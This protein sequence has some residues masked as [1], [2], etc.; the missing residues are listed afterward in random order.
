LWSLLFWSGGGLWAALVFPPVL[1]KQKLPPRPEP[2]ARVD[3][4]AYTITITVLCTACTLGVLIWQPGSNG[5]WLVVTVLAVTQAGGDASMKRTLARIAGTVV[6]V[7]IAGLVASVS[8]S[9]AVL[10]GVGLILLVIMVVI[11]LG[12]HSY[13]LHTVLVTP[14]VV[15]FSS[16][17]I[18]D[19]ATTDAQRLEFTLIAGALILLASGIAV[20]WAHYQRAHRPMPAVP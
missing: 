1:R 12:P 8:G 19:V 16:T 10:L 5:A 15:L 17:S 13:F 4:V 18:A 11:E 14:I 9:Q 7:V 20:G 6:G 2:W 3:V